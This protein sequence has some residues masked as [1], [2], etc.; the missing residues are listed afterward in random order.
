MKQRKRAKKKS[1]NAHSNREII[2]GINP[3][4]EVLRAKRRRLY[5]IWTAVKEPGPLVDEIFAIAG[6]EGIEVQKASR[7][8]IFSISR[9]EKNQGI[10]AEVDKFNY[11]SLEEVLI[12]AKKDE[13]GPFLLVLDNI[14][15]P[16]NLGSIIRTAHLVGCHGVIIQERNSAPIGPAAT[17]A[18][19]G[20][21]EYLPI[22]KVTN[23]SRVL[24][25]LKKE[26]LWV[27]G[28]EGDEGKNLYSY[29][30]SGGYAL[31][32][33]SEGKGLRRLVKEECDE[34]VS[35]PMSPINGGVGSY[36]VSVA[37]AIML[38]EVMRQRSK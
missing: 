13:K 19:A 21:V 11:K 28:A 22:V 4:F 24:K 38:S 29:V 6:S 1:S 5:K 25:L 18:S 30:F 15:D 2:S 14:L 37:A 26:G 8:E 12:K 27:V 16:Q 36:N 31:V 3:I 17:R 23:I 35:I 7:D 9:I 20:A 10:A 34:L 33:G 32:M